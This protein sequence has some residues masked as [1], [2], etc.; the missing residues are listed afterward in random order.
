MSP[1]IF[2]CGR[3]RRCF[4]LAQPAPLEFRCAL[5]CFDSFLSQ[6]LLFLLFFLQPFLFCNSL[7]FCFAGIIFWSLDS[8]TVWFPGWL[9]EVEM[10]VLST[11]F[12]AHCHGVLVW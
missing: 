8:V 7:A 2:C 11:V 4:F 12:C 1:F 9:R 10:A 6:L 3:R 5:I